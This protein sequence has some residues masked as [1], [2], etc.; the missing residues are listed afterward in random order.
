M[1]FV[2][3]CPVCSA[4]KVIPRRRTYFRHCGILHIVSDHIQAE[5]IRN[6]KILAE[7]SEKSEIPKQPKNND[8]L[9]EVEIE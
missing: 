4:N 9:I 8:N 3:K 5:S 6:V 1:S 2:V 7:K